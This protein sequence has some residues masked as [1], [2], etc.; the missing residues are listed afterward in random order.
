[1]PDSPVLSPNPPFAGTFNIIFPSGAT[2]VQFYSGCWDEP[3][4]GVITLYDLS[5]GVI[6]PLTN[7]SF[8]VWPSPAGVE[9]FD[10]SGF[11]TIAHITFN[12][13]ADPAGA[14]IDN[15][16]FH[17]VPEPSTLLILTIGFFGLAGGHV[18]P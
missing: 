16:Q 2:G 3:E 7:N 18:S 17:P 10:L 15:L 13:L 11:G 8:G 6:A 5:N 12:S 4:T 14:D 1:M 9:H